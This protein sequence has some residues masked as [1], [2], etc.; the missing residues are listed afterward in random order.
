MAEIS[1]FRTL[2]FKKMRAPTKDECPEKPYFDPTMGTSS[3]GDTFY[4]AGTASKIDYTYTLN[5]IDRP[6]VKIGEK[7]IQTNHRHFGTIG[8][9]HLD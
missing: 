3:P 8:D 6:P 4:Q 1:K 7:T 2:N 9:N 5:S